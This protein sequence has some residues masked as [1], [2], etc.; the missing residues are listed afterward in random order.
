MSTV[1]EPPNRSAPAIVLFD[2]VC[3]LC[4]RTVQIIIDHDPDGYFRFASLQSDQARRILAAHGVQ[5]PEGDPDS[6]L[7][8]HGGRVYSHSSAALRI[9]RRMRGAYRALWALIV[10][11]RFL[12]DAVYRWIARNRYRWFGREERCW[13]PS[14]TLEARFLSPSDGR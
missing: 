7:L 14:P 4:N 12:R 11:P 13:I 6:I 9:A 3:N 5:P 8:V 2:G 1:T 10:V